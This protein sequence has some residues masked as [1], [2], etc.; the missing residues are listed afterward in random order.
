MT[1]TV[2]DKSRGR[3]RTFHCAVRWK[4][5]RMAFASVPLYFDTYIARLTLK[6]PQGASS[7]SDTIVIFAKRQ[8]Q[9]Q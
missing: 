3:Y 8:K 9:F 4:E 7:R 5:A 1:K 6:P 2:E